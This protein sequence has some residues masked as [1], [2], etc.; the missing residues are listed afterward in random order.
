MKPWKYYST[1]VQNPWRTLEDWNKLGI[2]GASK[3][4]ISSWLFQSDEKTISEL[5]SLEAEFRRDACESLG[6]PEDTYNRL[7]PYDHV[8]GCPPNYEPPS[9]R[10]YEEMFMYLYEKTQHHKP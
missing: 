8:I 5:R 6:I 3:F 9:E 7:D 4:E 2:K 1:P 10:D